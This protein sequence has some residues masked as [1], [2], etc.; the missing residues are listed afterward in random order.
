VLIIVI[1]ILFKNMKIRDNVKISKSLENRYPRL[2]KKI[3]KINEMTGLYQYHVIFEDKE[4][5]FWES[6]LEVVLLNK[7]NHPLTSIFK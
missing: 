5:L 4:Y 2:R 7:I 3:G 1:I 6:E